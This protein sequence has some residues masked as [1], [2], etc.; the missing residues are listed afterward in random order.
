MASVKFFNRHLLVLIL[1]LSLEGSPLLGY[2]S[3]VGFETSQ[4]RQ[5]FVVELGYLLEVEVVSIIVAV[6]ELLVE[7][8]E[9][10]CSF[11][12]LLS[13]LIFDFLLPRTIGIFIVR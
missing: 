7:L 10:V 4:S 1:F 6:V 2:S 12:S 8:P 5:G 11:R 13:Y 3:A 9:P